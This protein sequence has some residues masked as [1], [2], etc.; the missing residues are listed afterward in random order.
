MAKG[1]YERKGKHGDVTYYIRYQ[2]HGK[3]VR[4]KVGRK[5]RGF[6]REMA[7][8][9]L[10]SRLGEVAQGRF[11]LEKTRKP[12]P[13]SKLVERY[14]EYASSYKRA[15][16]EEK[17]TFERIAE[18][19]GDTPLSQITTWQIEKWKAER[20][21][22][23]K[24]GTVNRQLTV[25][26]HM[27]KKAVEWGLATSN[28]AAAVKRF[29][30]N[31]QRTRFLTEDEIQRLL[32]V[33]EAQLTSPWLLPLVT[34]ALNT[35]MRQGELLGLSWV[36][37]DLERGLITTKRTKN[38]RLKAIPLNEP[39]REALAWLNEHRYG[40]YLFMWPWGDLLGK[41]TVYD[42]FRTACD[43]A[44]ITDFRFH[45][46][47]HT[48]ASHLIM[49]GADL[50]TVMELLGHVGINMT[51]RYSH[52]LPEH[53]AQALARLGERYQGLKNE[54]E[55]QPRIVSQE[56]KQAIG[57]V[58]ASDL[59]QNRHIFMVRKGRGLKIVSNIE[60][61]EMARDRIEL[62]TRG[63]SVPTWYLDHVLPSVTN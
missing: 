6:T 56:L 35:G 12:V 58:Q 2:F 5:S 10:K 17:Y 37:V 23:V 55:P 22:E 7:R 21:K 14:R 36:E 3:D 50:V 27:C 32:I 26:K 44:G 62:P 41:T 49:A 24:P 9:A 19:F 11:N 16:D 15:W 60:R 57:N 59:A 13:F 39:A 48:F 28:P 30:V 51:L 1:I 45:D 46:L 47:R 20:R 38:L 53:K 54:S 18:H 52:L 42:A 43:Q 29:A 63:F 8:E 61:L 25:I 4:E 34:L 33:C 31:D 40:D